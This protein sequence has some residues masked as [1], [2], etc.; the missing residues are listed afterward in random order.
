[1]L[2]N[3]NRGVFTNRSYEY[4]GQT[5]FRR[6]GSDYM[7]ALLTSASGGSVF[8]L[9]KSIANADIC[10]VAGGKPGGAGDYDVSTKQGK[11]GNGGEIVN[12]TGVYLPAGDYTVTIGGSDGNTVLAA[13]DG[14]TWTSRSGYGST[15]GIGNGAA[16]DPGNYA[17]NDA[18]TTLYP[19]WK[20][21]AGGGHG[22]ILSNQYQEIDGGAGG[23][24]G[25]ASADTTLGHGGTSAHPKGY[26]GLANVGQGGGGGSRIWSGSY[27]DNYDGGAGGS[28]II[29]IRKHKEA[30]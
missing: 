30:S 14:R 21:G 24:V 12:V 6:S 25:T 15:G 23:S 3:L 1:M 10:L 19:G 8:R 29:L 17:W 11:G 9:L 4:S 5:D 2:F 16:G 28:G 27:Y 22:Y 13:P 18:N 26:D 7:F 20:F